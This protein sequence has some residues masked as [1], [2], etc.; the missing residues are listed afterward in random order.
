MNYQHSLLQSLIDRNMITQ[1][2]AN[3]CQQ[4]K[5]QTP[6]K[7]WIE[8]L[9][10][11]NFVSHQELE[12]IL[13]ASEEKTAFSIPGYEMIAPLGKGGMGSV[14]KARQTNLN[15][16]VAIKILQ[17]E[18][19]N[20]IS[21]FA[22]EAKLLAQISHPNIV[23]ILDF[24]KTNF[25][26]Y[27]MEY[28]AGDNLSQLVKKRGPMSQPCAL[29]VIYQVLK[30]LDC[31]HKKNI[32]HRDIKPGNIMVKDDG[33]VKL[34]DL[35]L[36]KSQ[37]QKIQHTQHNA[38]LGTPS[39]MSPEQIEQA[40]SVD[41]RSDIYSL[42]VT[43]FFLLT[44]KA[45][46]QGNFASVSFQHMHK[47][48]PK[49]EK[50]SPIVDNLLKDMTAKDV[51][52]RFQSPSEIIA[53]L[54]KANIRNCES[55]WHSY[56]RQ[57]VK[58]QKKESIHSQKTDIQTDNNVEQKTQRAVTNTPARTNVPLKNS[59]AKKIHHVTNPSPSPIVEIPQH[60]TA[61]QPPQ[62]F[63]QRMKRRLFFLSGFIPLLFLLQDIKIFLIL[64]WYSLLVMNHFSPKYFDFFH[65]IQ[66]KT[67]YKFMFIS[68]VGGTIIIT[69][70]TLLDHPQKVTKHPKLFFGC[71]IFLEAGVSAI[72]YRSMRK[73]LFTTKE[74]A[75][76]YLITPVALS[77][78]LESAIFGI[79]A[80]L[81]I[82]L[83]HALLD[84]QLGEQR[85][86]RRRK[87]LVVLQIL[88]F[89]FLVMVTIQK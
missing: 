18:N 43:L 20:V 42:G 57:P 74:I 29:Y 25:H 55:K 22:Q 27:I 54:E 88:L 44:G 13:A 69:C 56:L 24:G 33:I 28:I 2:Q 59:S 83:T 62:K 40:N 67:F 32:I 34:C 60:H 77:L 16:P 81:P 41:I 17:L 47:P 65:R 21:R 19:P 37:D 39:Y 80:G 66:W 64:V 14:F 10:A 85:V 30:A 53:I 36:A 4:I 38:V 7:S 75:L 87:Y 1:Q 6:H 15:R 23:S 76:T 49:L 51:N 3:T 26:Y 5:Q 58:L 79:I 46:Y 71:I 89:V 78:Q 35:G 9:L 72:W 52:K 8:I 50:I 68:V 73:Y 45:P 84:N 70:C 12:N 63:L 48:L 61:N 31:I 82:I 11:N 86:D